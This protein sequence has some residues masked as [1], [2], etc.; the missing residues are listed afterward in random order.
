VTSLFSERGRAV[1][2]SAGESRTMLAFDFDGTLAPIVR[3]P[4]S[5]AMRRGTRALL[6]EVARLYP[7][8]ILSG[9]AVGDLR[10]RFDGVPVRWFIGN[11]GAEGVTRAAPDRERVLR[12]RK[13]L[14]PVAARNGG[15]TIE[16][17]R[18]SLAIHY[19]EATDGARA[20]RAIL[21][22]ASAL[23]GAR[24]VPGKRVINLVPVEAPDKGA[25]LAALVA[26]VRPE[27]VLFAGDDETDEDAFQRG[28]DVPYVTVRVGRTVRTHARF[29][30]G[31]QKAVDR[32]LMALL[33]GRAARMR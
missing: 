17:K 20:R 9:R 30:V 14:R 29:F 13:A 3:S 32:L 15:V 10:S 25:A 22:V 11:H 6:R 26:R 19:R 28:L 33:A 5:A 24:V 7:C 8:A 27:M 18:L 1:L 21:N 23:Q 2:A 16:D 31:G 4:G 12:W